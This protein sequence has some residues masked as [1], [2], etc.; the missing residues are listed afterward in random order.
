MSQGE[1]YRRRNRFRNAKEKKPSRRF[2]L[3]LLVILLAF[4]WL[5][6][7]TNQPVD[8][9]VTRAFL[10]FFD[11]PLQNSVEYFGGKAAWDS[12]RTSEV[13][14]NSL[15]DTAGDDDA[16]SKLLEEEEAA[17]SLPHS[18]NSQK[19]EGAQAD[20]SVAASEMLAEDG[21]VVIPIAIGADVFDYSQW[22]YDSYDDYVAEDPIGA[23]ISYARLWTG[24]LIQKAQ[25]SGCSSCTRGQEVGPAAEP[26][27]AMR[28]TEP[29]PDNGFVFESIGKGRT[30]QL[31]VVAPLDADVFIKL[32]DCATGET[33]LSFYVKA[34]A[35]VAACV[36]AGTY[37]LFSGLGTEWH[38]PD[39]A[40]GDAGL[41]L[42][43]DASLSFSNPDAT[44]T[45]TLG[46]GEG[47]VSPV[48]ISKT[49][50]C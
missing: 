22:G 3:A 49:E 4:L 21:E 13:I 37:E 18:M 43:S 45:Y 11:L 5:F 46:T 40:F 36:P 19:D 20:E 10:Q 28:K 29:R 34:G 14:I 26:Q 1:E 44:Y 39:E 24:L 23:K 8:K 38:G 9:A 33:A 17:A 25:P 47:N 6:P 42:R 2:S 35:T 48:A 32:K 7:L 27:N 12:A 16:T 15:G 31:T 30:P 50:F 41:Y